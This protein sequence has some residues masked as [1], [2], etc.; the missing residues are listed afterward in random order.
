MSPI[1]GIPGASGNNPVQDAAIEE[2]SET[3]GSPAELKKTAPNELKKPLDAVDRATAKQLFDPAT[4]A[5][6]SGPKHQPQHVLH[7]FAEMLPLLGTA[8][9]PAHE[10]GKKFALDGLK[11]APPD[12]VAPPPAEWLAMKSDL[13]QALA[14]N[15]EP[16]PG[17]DVLAKL[18]LV[19]SALE[20][21]KKG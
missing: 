9:P 21:H 12:T 4:R 19:M 5:H 13:Q 15:P 2:R 6:A 17:R 16:S 20:K 10:V 7:A 8:P 11:E 18:Q 1:K 14:A 3:R